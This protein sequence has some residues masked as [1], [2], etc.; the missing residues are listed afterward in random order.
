[1]ENMGHLLEHGRTHTSVTLFYEGNGRSRLKTELFG[2]IDLNEIEIKEK[3]KEEI[4]RF[5][6]FQQIFMG[7]SK[8]INVGKIDIRNYAKYVL[9]EG[10]DIEKR[11]LLGCIKGGIKLNNKQISMSMEK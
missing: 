8:K 3:I 1:M 7:T 9:R 2:K 10:K 11:E 4:E 6:K 5:K